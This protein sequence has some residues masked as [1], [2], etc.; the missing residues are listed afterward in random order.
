MK[1]NGSLL[2]IACLVAALCQPALGGS[3]FKYDLDV[4]DE[5]VYVVRIEVQ[6]PAGVEYLGGV[7]HFRGREGGNRAL[8]ATAHDN[9]RRAKSAARLPFVFPTRSHWLKE[10][11]SVPERGRP[12]MRV[13]GELPML[14]GNLDELFFPAAS[15]SRR[16]PDRPP[17]RSRPWWR[18]LS[19]HWHAF[20]R[21]PQQ[22]GKVH[23]DNAADQRFGHFAPLSSKA[24]PANA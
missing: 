14:M 9:L 18:R 23:L 8:R 19:T 20:Q 5:V 12:L 24:T 21:A 2:V 11:Y 4:G 10:E 13:K 15:N 6:S 16:F 22:V 7:V 1:Q 17:R 3:P